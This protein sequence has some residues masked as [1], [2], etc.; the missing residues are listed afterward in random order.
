V[1]TDALV[2]DKNHP[3]WKRWLSAEADARKAEL[4][5]DTS[6]VKLG[7]VT[8]IALDASCAD[9]ESMIAEAKSD[10]EVAF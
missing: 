1:F 2:T 8:E 5:I 4:G 7:K 3:L 6:G 10:S 9:L